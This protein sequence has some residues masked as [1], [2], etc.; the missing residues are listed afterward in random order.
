MTGRLNTEIE[1]PS[2]DVSNVLLALAALEHLGGAEHYVDIEN[3]TLEA[4][5]IAPDRFSWRTR[6]DYPSWER[7]RTA[8]VHANQKEQKRE[9]GLLVVSNTDGSSWKLTANG[10]AFV[11]K[12]A[13]RIEGLAAKG[14]PKRRSG[15]SAERVRQIRRHRAFQA[16]KHGTP[17]ADMARHQL[18]DIL[19]CPPDSP[20]EGVRRKL[21]AAKAA[22]V[23]VDDGEVGRF[24][25]ELGKEV[26][27]KW[28]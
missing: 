20:Q 27:H 15:K 10:V 6:R 22:A 8:F 5:R 4:Y 12:Y 14:R 24:L 28:S 25:E 23:D 2:V 7:V 19:L 18:A 9:G 1:L 3:V 17:V 16:F 11:R 26:E 21:D 13:A